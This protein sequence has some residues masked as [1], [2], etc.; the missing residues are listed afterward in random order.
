[1][2]RPLER[3]TLRQSR[4][5]MGESQENNHSSYYW[6]QEYTT[7]KTPALV[8]CLPFKGTVSSYFLSEN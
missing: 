1:M 2:K 7:G 4:G 5:T 8:A 3:T 6:L